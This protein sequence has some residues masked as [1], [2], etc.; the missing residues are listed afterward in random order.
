MSINTRSKPRR[1]L[2]HW[3]K[4]LVVLGAVILSPSA[5]LF[6]FYIG[7]WLARWT[8]GLKIIRTQKKQTLIESQKVIETQ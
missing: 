3:R 1:A 2:R 7:F 5:V 4:A 6:A 8:Y